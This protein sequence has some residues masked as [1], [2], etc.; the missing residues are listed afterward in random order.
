MFTLKKLVYLM[1]TYVLTPQQGLK[2]CCLLQHC[3]VITLMRYPKNLDFVYVNLPIVKLFFFKYINPSMTLC[4]G[5]LYN[6][7]TSSFDNKVINTHKIYPAVLS[8]PTYFLVPTLVC[9]LHEGGMLVFY[10]CCNKLP[11]T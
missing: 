4:E 1:H 10:C 7:Y 6:V 9:K 5:L 3:F 2:Q 8:L 11:P